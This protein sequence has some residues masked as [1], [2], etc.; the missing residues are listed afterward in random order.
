MEVKVTQPITYVNV[1][2]QE[3]AIIQEARRI[4]QMIDTMD[5]SVYG[6]TVRMPI[7]QYNEEQHLIVSRALEIERKY[8]R[9]Y[10][11]QH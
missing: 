9:Q 5:A 3:A 1:Y 2:D 7:R 11:Y 6:S 8:Q 10:G 4:D